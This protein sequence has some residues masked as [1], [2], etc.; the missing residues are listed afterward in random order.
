MARGT[1]F[2]GTLIRMSTMAQEKGHSHSC[3]GN[4]SAFSGSL[5]DLRA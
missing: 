5:G 3:N 1:V 4:V 2:E